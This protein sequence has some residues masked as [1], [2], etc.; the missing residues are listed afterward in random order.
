[1]DILVIDDNEILRRTVGRMLAG[2]D[3]TIWYA[4]NGLDGLR[5]Y[6]R[7]R[8]Q[9]VILDILMPRDDGFEIM[10]ELHA[11]NPDLPILVI[12]GAWHLLEKARRLGA[13]KALGKPFSARQLRDA[14]ALC[15]G[16]RPDAAAP[17]HTYEAG[18]AG[19]GAGLSRGWRVA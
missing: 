18:R 13:T 10:R 16:G 6:L 12:S 9:L 19:A 3:E 2:P 11:I 15:L 17:W 14:V 8:Q 1:M 7:E 4:D 5:S